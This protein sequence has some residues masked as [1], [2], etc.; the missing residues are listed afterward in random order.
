MIAG[1]FVSNF[2]RATRTMSKLWITIEVEH[3]GSCCT[4][5]TIVEARDGRPEAQR[6]PAVARYR[7]SLGP[8][9]RHLEWPPRDHRRYRGAPRPLFR[10]QRAVLAG[11]AGPVR[12]RRGRAG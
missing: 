7:R 8:G 12:Y 6:K 2:A 9:D 10:Q 3:H 4:S 11:P 1:G 5:R